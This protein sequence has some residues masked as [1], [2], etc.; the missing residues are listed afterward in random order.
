MTEDYV[1]IEPDDRVLNKAATLASYSSQRR[2]WEK[3][4]SDEHQV[5]VYGET[6]I[7]IGRW[8]A[9]GVNDGVAFDYSA[10]FMSIYVKRDGI[11]QMAAEQATLILT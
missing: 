5:T 10:R 11:R 7:L 8:T 4:V 2:S 3:A 1:M 6:A 9:K